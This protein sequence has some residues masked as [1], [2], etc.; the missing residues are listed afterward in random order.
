MRQITH[1]SEKL[2]GKL[3]GRFRVNYGNSLEIKSYSFTYQN[4][5]ILYSIVDLANI[6]VI[7]KTRKI[8]ST[9]EGFFYG[10]F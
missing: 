1:W 6:N 9:A 4:L 8:L 10:I 3:P 2:F 7:K 5:R